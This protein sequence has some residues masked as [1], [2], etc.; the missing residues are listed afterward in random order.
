MSADESSV[1][2]EIVAPSI[3]SELFPSGPSGARQKAVRVGS[4]ES[5]AI[6][7]I[8]G[9]LSP[10]AV[11][12]SLAICMLCFRQRPSTNYMALGIAAFLFSQQAF[13]RLDS[14]LSRGETLS[15]HLR[16]WYLVVG[17]ISVLGSL[18]IFGLLLN[19]A[20]LYS[21]P[22]IFSWFWLTP[23]AL[24]LAS[25]LG[26]RAARQALSTAR[27]HVIVGADGVGAELA[28]RI[29]S[30]ARH[31]KFMGFFDFRSPERLP[32]LGRQHLA[33][34][35][36]DLAA[37]VRDHSIGAIYIALP[38]SN[39]PRIE[40]LLLELRDTTA[41]VYFV[42]N[43]FSFDLIQPRCSAIDGIAVISICDTPFYGMNAVRKRLLDLT[44][45]ICA[46][47]LSWPLLLVLAIVVRL[48]S[49]GPIIF[50]QRRYGL[51]GEEIVIY[52]FR[53][54]TV[55]EDGVDIAQAG[56][57]DERTTSL[58]RFLRRSSLDELPQI[59]NVLEGKMSFVGPRPHAVA[60]NEHYRRLISGYMIRHKIRPG[61]TGWAQINGYRG[62][63]ETIEKMRRRVACDIEYLRN[64]SIWLD[65]KIVA[66]TA[67]M[68]FEGRNAY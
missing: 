6:A 37:F 66:K 20:Q 56:R 36:R 59:F 17:W 3:S 9:V 54:M 4:V 68:L 24:L 28:R 2:C 11:V 57:D 63:T 46:L 33:G 41:S 62:E 43:V 7:L 52:K 34:H 21:R 64:W 16:L 5:P 32:E 65:L 14:Q 1:D 53:T 67:F 26:E 12:I 49:P 30:A 61:I 27:R 47:L 23:I 22:V 35:C 15:A 29:Q 55:C 51:H 31:G 8:S 25:H 38:I 39:A 40:E 19:V 13:R 48:S 42:P 60:H 45:A 10:L 58:G 50:K 18:S 44:L